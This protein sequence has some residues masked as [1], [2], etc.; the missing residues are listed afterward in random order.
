[1]NRRSKV[2]PGKAAG[3]LDELRLMMNHYPMGGDARVGLSPVRVL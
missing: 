3:E 2:N 1:M